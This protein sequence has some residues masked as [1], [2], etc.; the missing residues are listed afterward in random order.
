MKQKIWTMGSVCVQ[1]DSHWKNRPEGHE[2][3][4]QI[5]S[6][7]V[8]EYLNRTAY[9]MG[10]SAP[11]VKWDIS[12]RLSPVTFPFYGKRYRSHKWQLLDG[13]PNMIQP[14]KCFLAS[15]DSFSELG[16]TP[17]CLYALGITKSALKF[18]S[19]TW[20]NDGNQLSSLHKPVFI[21]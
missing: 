8:T 10:L 1:G 15:L 6:L 20:W 18:W 16:K 14:T 12:G 4:V 7:P 9:F 11:S 5:L 21:K 19:I 2:A 3:W 17:G 13:D